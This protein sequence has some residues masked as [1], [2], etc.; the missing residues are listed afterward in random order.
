M[1][2]IKAGRIPA[3]FNWAR[4]LRSK[5]GIDPREINNLRPK[6]LWVAIEEATRSKGAS[7]PFDASGG[8]IRKRIYNALMILNALGYWAD[9][10]ESSARQMAFNYDSMHGIYGTICKAIISSDKR[11]LRRLRAAYHYIDIRTRTVLV[12]ADQFIEEG[13]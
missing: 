7:L 10:I 6:D 9:V 8:P 12:R 3:K 4:D 2:E 5:L 11:F 1:D 13:D